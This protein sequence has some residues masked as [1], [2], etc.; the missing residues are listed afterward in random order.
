MP[1]NYGHVEKVNLVQISKELFLI[2]KL[3]FKKNS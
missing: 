1:E 2:S 3:D